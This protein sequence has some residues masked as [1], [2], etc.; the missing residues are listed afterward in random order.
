L[1]PKDGA[2]V[3][4]TN[5]VNCAGLQSDRIARMVGA[6]V[7]LTIIPFRGE[8]YDLTPEARS[9]CKNLIYPVPDPQ[10]PFLGVHLTRAPDNTVEAGPNA[11]LAWRREG[12]KKTDFSLDDMKELLGFR[13]FW[14][15]A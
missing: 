10:F 8:Y 6:E 14:Q 4:A 7:D 2:E 1:L 11:V 5:L 9:L 12:Y 15:M 3:R 13:G